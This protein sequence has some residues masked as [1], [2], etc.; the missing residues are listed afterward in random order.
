MPKDFRQAGNRSSTRGFSSRS[1]QGASPMK[2]SA[3]RVKV[4][5]GFTLLALAACNTMEGAG[6]DIQS[7]G[8]ALENSAQRNK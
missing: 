1:Q 8:K 6:E 7:G 4:L 2:S 5:I 3:L